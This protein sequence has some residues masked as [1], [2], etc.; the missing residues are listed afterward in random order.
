M[1]SLTLQPDEGVNSVSVPA[2]AHLLAKEHRL[3]CL[4]LMELTREAFPEGKVS[5]DFLSL[6]TGSELNFSS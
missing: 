6:I 2:R 4:R 1:L 3:R 5:K